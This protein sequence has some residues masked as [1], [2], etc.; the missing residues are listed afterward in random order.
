[1][2]SQADKPAAAILQLPLAIAARRQAPPAARRPPPQKSDTR[3]NRW[4]VGVVGCAELPA[5]V[6]SSPLAQEEIVIT[7][8]ANGEIAVTL[9]SADADDEHLASRIVAVD[10][11][12]VRLLA[13][14]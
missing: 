3:P 11:K 5:G 9:G 13:T 10:D 7:F 2:S 4:S 12:I 1:V 14:P 8:D 6:W